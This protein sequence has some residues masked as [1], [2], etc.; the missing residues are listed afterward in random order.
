MPIVSSVSSRVVRHETRIAAVAAVIAGLLGCAGAP[1]VVH[2]DLLEPLTV[3]QPWL[4]SVADLAAARLARAALVAK[5]TGGEASPEVATA[6]A[7]LLGADGPAHDQDLVPLAA[8]L[9]NATLDDPIL[10]REGARRLRKEWGL[11]PRLVSRLDRT[12]G[13]DPLKLAGR[14]QFDGWHR[15]WARTFNAVVEPIGSSAI[16]GFALAPYQL[17]NS[18]IHYFAEFSNSEPLSGTN[19]QGLALRQEFVAKHPDTAISAEVNE[20]IERDLPKLEAT[21]ARRRIR[22][23][24]RALESGSAALALHHA[25]A[26]LRI[27]KAHPEA[28]Q[29]LQRSAEESRKLAETATELERRQRATADEAIATPAALRD[30]ERAITIALLQ[31]DLIPNRLIA[32]IDRYRTKALESGRSAATVDGKISFVRALAQHDAGYEASARERLA[33]IANA[34]P[35]G[36]PMVRHARALLDDDWQNPHGGF[37]RLRR[38]AGRDEFAWRVAGDW[39]RRPRYPNL[40]VPLAYLIDTPT[41]AMTIALAPLRLVIS[42]FTG[43]TPDFRRAPALAGYR[44]LIRYPAGEEQRPVIDWLYE[45]ELDQE[46]WGRALRMADWIPDFPE[47]LRAELVEKTATERVDRLEQLERRDERASILTGV[48]REF[49]DSEGGQLAGM[50]A[51]AEREDASPQFIRIT[52]GFLVENPE[53]AGQRGIGLN[54]ALLNEDLADGELHSE[55]IVLRG[56]RILEIR[57]IAEGSNDKGPPE[58]RTVK[59]SKER[60]RQLAAALDEAVQRNSLVDAASRFSADPNRDLFLERAGL[61]LTDAPDLRPTAQSSFVYQSLRERYGMVRG[62]DSVLPFDLVFRGSLGDFSLGAFPRWRAP[63]E[64]PDAFLYR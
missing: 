1:T 20:K 25:K 51:R 55:G 2:E 16:T 23:S 43:G 12:I 58:S 4:P 56:G 6:F 7:A 17:T 36:D 38:K 47:D 13:D 44:Y 63:R 54:P 41:I 45:Y 32:P 26:A 3:S 19:R 64:T 5:P 24:E 34:S 62:R 35:D 42:P 49:P 14:R 39:V 40:P 28:N 15:L 33:E 57:L 48:A 10:Y 61:G 50:Q 53:V 22:G 9:R 18:L 21:L 8:D 46:R 11:D 37:E 52:R 27:L 31:K 60:L 59:L 29:R 30:A